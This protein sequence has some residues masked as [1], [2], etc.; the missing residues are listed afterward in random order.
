M[1]RTPGGGPANATGTPMETPSPYGGELAGELSEPIDS[2]ETVIGGVRVRVDTM[3][4]GLE[5]P[6]AVDFSKDGRIF[7]TERVGRVRVIGPGGLLERS[8]ST[9][10][11]VEAEASRP[12]EPPTWWVKGGEGGLLGLALH[13]EFPDE[14][15]VYMH[16]TYSGDGAQFNRV[17]RIREEKLMGGRE[18]VLLDGIPGGSYHDGGRIKFGQDGLLYICTGDAGNGG[19]AQ[20]LGSLGGKIL[21][22]T[23]DGEPAPGNPFEEGPYVYSYGHRN[24]Q[25]LAFSADGELFATE[26][27]EVGHDEVNLIE[28]GG[29]YGWQLHQGAPDVEGF[30]DPLIHSG[31]DTWAPSGAAF[32]YGP[33]DAWSGSLFFA[34]LRGEALHRLVV[35][36]REVR[37]HEVL[38]K[39][40]YGRLR[41]A[42]VGPEGGLYILTSNRDGRGRSRR[43]DDRLFRI[44]PGGGS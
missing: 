26:H 11:S 25:G 12:G 35:D 3:A 19:N 16:Y 14:P 36:G 43:G 18:E 10:P 42:V 22:M 32:Y 5:V 23:P 8:Y 6:W 41:D 39:D 28:R 30:V 31:T 21:R 2:V 15:W 13:P 7:F 4:E 38:L 9:P 17:S 29:N 24:P 37:K 40:R 1:N 20:D 34:A 33:I 27:G 44:V